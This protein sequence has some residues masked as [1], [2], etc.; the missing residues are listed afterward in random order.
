[1][2]TWDNLRALLDGVD[3]QVVD[4]QAERVAAESALAACRAT[5]ATLTAQVADLQ[6]QLAASR[7]GHL[8]GAAIHQ[9][10]GET[11][12]Q[13]FARSDA[14][15]GPLRILRSYL[16]DKDMIGGPPSW[17]TRAEMTPATGIPVQVSFKVTMA[18]V[19]AGTYD[20][21]Y[22]A[23]FK[24]APTDRDIYW[25]MYHEPDD[26][27]TAGKFSCEQY[28]SALTRLKGL[29]NQAGNPRLHCTISPMNWTLSA[30]SDRAWGSSKFPH[31]WLDLYAGHPLFGGADDIVDVVAW[32]VNAFGKYAD[33]AALFGL[34]E[35]AMRG[36]RWNPATGKYLTDPAL[37]VKARSAIAEWGGALVG[38]DTGQGRADWIRACGRYL[39]T[40][41]H[42]Y[43]CYFDN[44]VGGA[45]S[46]LLDK[47]SV[48]AMRDLCTGNI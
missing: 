44:P 27:V 2:S 12:A 24:G 4:A 46:Q 34:V 20:A 11:Y 25:T 29:A 45:G 33:P 41:V 37:A 10:S 15:Y 18:A 38:T 32:D 5:N 26:D 14:A 8:F 40:S 39:K 7:P 36:E 47:L 3:A 31:G 43:S 19:I 28:R 21:K 13:A 42:L 9:N 6:A 48:A 16:A 17:A 35:R 1:M 22:L 30:D 23:W